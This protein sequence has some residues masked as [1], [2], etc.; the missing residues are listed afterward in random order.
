MRS[1]R[2]ALPT[3]EQEPVVA[4][5][6]VMDPAKLA[7]VLR[8]PS[9]P[10]MRRLIEDGEFVKDRARSYVR[11]HKPVP[12]ERR[13][14]R[15]GQLRDS[16]VKRIRG[17]GVVEVGS[18]DPIALI[19]HE[20]T[21]PHPITSKGK[22]LVFYWPKVGRVVAFPPWGKPPGT[23]HHP[24]TTGSHYLTRALADLRRRY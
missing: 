13:N 21:E 4:A 7:E 8:S 24:G 12:Q 17:E 2:D 9:G 14:R 6:V 3:D 16:I 15:P 23:V 19:E 22:P 1:G 11:V 20:G 18:D 10:V 5:R